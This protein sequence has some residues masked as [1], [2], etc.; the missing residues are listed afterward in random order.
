[1]KDALSVSFI[2]SCWKR[3]FLNSEKANDPTLLVLN[4]GACAE[5]ETVET[6]SLFRKI[7]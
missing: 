7:S 4:I 3:I 5:S 2:V 6:L 1:M